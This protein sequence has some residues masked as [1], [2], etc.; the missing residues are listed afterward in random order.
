MTQADWLARRTNYLASMLPGLQ[1][2]Y[3]STAWKWS[4][5]QAMGDNDVDQI[6][7][8]GALNASIANAVGPA[9]DAL[10]A[11]F[12]VYR[13]PA[14]RATVPIVFS[15]NPVNPSAAT[16]I[17]TGA[18]VLTPTT[19]GQ[20]SVQFTTL[21]DATIPANSANSNTV[22]AQCLTTGT[23]GNVAIGTVTIP[24]SG[25]P[26][27][28]TV[29][30]PAAG[31][32]SGYVAGAAAQSDDSYRAAIFDAIQNQTAA[33]RIEGVAKQQSGTWGAVFAAHLVDA[34]DQHG[35]YTLYVCDVAGNSGASLQTAVTNAVNA[36]TNIG[37]TPTIAGLTLVTQNIVGTYTL[38]PGAVS[39]TVNAGATAA[40][41]AWS[42]TLLN[43]VN[44][45]P[46]DFILACYGQKKGIAAVPGLLDLT[47]STP[48]APVSVDATHIA[49]VGT[50][51][52]TLGSI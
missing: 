9:L 14:I 47:L 49:R 18:V 23:A 46:T 38:Q 19:G 13:Q 37:L 51:T 32:S 28:V 20:G 31:G 50:I 11:G 12:N 5:A 40:M 17:S 4:N 16:T 30:N 26:A 41:Q 35:N 43:G 39:A 36:M 52:L 15:L 33:A 45:L 7:Q 3:G 42:A 6:V 10:G 44:F 8:Q 48:S 27:G 24:Y 34:A 25:V 21:A 29:S 1:T 22:T 2:A